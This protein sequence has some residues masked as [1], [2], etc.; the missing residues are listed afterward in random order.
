VPVASSF[1]INR[2]NVITT[3]VAKLTPFFTFGSAHARY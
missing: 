3:E 1:C 2:I